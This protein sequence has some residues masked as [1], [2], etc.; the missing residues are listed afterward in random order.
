MFRSSTWEEEAAKDD[1]DIRIAAARLPRVKD[2]FEA[3][4]CAVG[5]PM[6]RVELKGTETLV[7]LNSGI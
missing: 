6:M 5:C 7:L 4:L 2:G 3:D 1:A